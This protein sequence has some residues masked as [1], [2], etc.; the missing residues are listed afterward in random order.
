MSDKRGRYVA[1][2]DEWLGAESVVVLV[3]DGTV[4]NVHRMG[5]TP[6]GG[7][8]DVHPR[9]RGGRQQSRA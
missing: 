5:P 8:V 2:V 6:E 1:I 4:P 3:L 9:V 7:V